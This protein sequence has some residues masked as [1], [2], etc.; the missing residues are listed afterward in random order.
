MKSIM[1]QTIWH[2]TRTNRSYMQEV[3]ASRTKALAKDFPGLGENTKSQKSETL[4]SLVCML[5]LVTTEI[6]KIHGIHPWKDGMAYFKT[7][8]ELMLIRCTHQKQQKWQIII[9]WQVT[10]VNII[11]HS[12]NDDLGIKMN[13]NKHGTMEQMKSISCWTFW[14]II[15]VK[16]IYGWGV[17]AWW[18]EA[19]IMR[20]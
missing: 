7:H 10:A 1:R 12:C 14:Y 6:T 4:R 9:F 16:W 5:V 3:I 20:N 13:P 19:Y 8:V 11:W 17:M 2:I 15:H 18:T